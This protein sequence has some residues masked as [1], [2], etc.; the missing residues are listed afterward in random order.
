M[1][2]EAIEN[3]MNAFALRH[4]NAAIQQLVRGAHGLPI[5]ANVLSC[6]LF[7]GIEVLFALIITLGC[8]R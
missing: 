6:L 5:E 7:L 2:S 1:R 8:R 4:Y 3:G